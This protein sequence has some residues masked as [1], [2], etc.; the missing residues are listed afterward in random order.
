MVIGYNFLCVHVLILYVCALMYLC[1][2]ALVV[3]E[4]VGGRGGGD[5]VWKRIGMHVVYI[6]IYI[7]LDVWWRGNCKSA[8]D[9][10]SECGL[11]EPSLIFECISNFVLVV[12][13]NSNIYSVFLAAEVEAG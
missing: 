1:V 5:Y 7:C 3:S 4:C 11:S 9:W 10:F 8:Y 12:I 13:A 2:I 6:T